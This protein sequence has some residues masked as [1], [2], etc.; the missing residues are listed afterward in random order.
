[1]QW[2]WSSSKPKD[3]GLFNSNTL[4]VFGR[5]TGGNRWK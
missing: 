5:R 1:L 3:D 2:E 4:D